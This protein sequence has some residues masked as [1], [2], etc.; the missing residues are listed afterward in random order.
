VRRQ[1]ENALI[2][3]AR[4]IGK[5]EYGRPLFGQFSVISVEIAVSDSAKNLI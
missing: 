4:K 2:V 1:V 3:T 5:M